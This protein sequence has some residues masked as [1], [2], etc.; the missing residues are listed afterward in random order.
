MKI[1]EIINRLEEIKLKYGDLQCLLLDEYER[2]GN[3]YFD[4][5]YVGVKELESK[6]FV[7]IQ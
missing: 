7:E 6:I 5:E 1:S 4:I 3:P 2:S